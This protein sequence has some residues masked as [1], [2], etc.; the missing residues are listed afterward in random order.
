MRKLYL[1]LLG[2]V[3]FA[4]QALAQRTITG[5]VTDEKGNAL[6]NVSVVVKGTTAGTS[7]KSDGTFSLV[8]PANAKLLVVSSVDMIA[9]ELTIGSQSNFT[10]ALKADDKTLQEAVVVGYG[11][12]KKPSITGSVA[13]VKATDI[14]NKPFSSVDKIL[15][16]QVAGL[17]SV[18]ASGQPGAAQSIIIR[19][20]SSISAS[21]GPLWVVDGVPVNTG[22][23][24]RLQ[25]TANLLSTINPNDIESISVLKDAASQSIYG[26]RASN[27]VIIVTTKKGRA[28]K[29]RVRFDSELGMS[30]TAYQNKLYTPLNAQQFFDVTREG[31]INAGYGANA[32]A[33]DPIMAS[34]FGYGNGI[35]YSWLD[36]VTRNGSQQQYNLSLDGGNERTT[37][38]VSGGHFK[39]EG[40][41]INS[42]LSRNSGNIRITNKVSD[43]VTISTNIN[44]AVVNQRAPLNGGAFGNPVL[45]SYFLL[46]S[47]SAYNPDGSYNFTALGGLHNTVALTKIDKRFLRQAS[48]RGSIAA[49][50]AIRKNLKFRTSY[51]ADFNMLEEDQ[52][53]N[54]V[55]GDGVA[56]NGRSFAYYTRYYNWVW[57]NTLNWNFKLSKNGDLTNDMQVGYEA[58]KS[59]GYFASIQAQIMP[60]NFNMTMP[61][62][63]ALPI[64]ANATISEYSFLS[65]FASTN[66]NYQNRFI[67]SGSF[68]RDGS[69]RFSVNNK[70]GNFWSI[71][72]S[73]NMEKEEIIKNIKWINQLKLRAS[74]GV[75]GNAGIG[76][77]DWFQ[78]YSYGATYNQQ[79]GS[80]FSNVGDSS[81]TWEK[82]KPTNIGFDISLFKNR[83]SV[84]FDYYTRTTESLLL[85]VPLSRTSGLTSATKNLGTMENKG[86]ELTISGTP[87]VLKNFRWNIDFNFANNKNKVTALPGG[88]DIADGSFIIRQGVAYRTFFLR[89]YAGVNPVNGDPLWYTDATHANKTNAYPGGNA[90]NLVGN[91]LP[92]YFGSL[93]NNFTIGAFTVQCQLYY[94]FGNYV[95]DTWGSYYAGAGFGGSYNKVVRVLN[96]WQKPGDVTD[97]PK[98]IYGGNKSFQSSSTMWLNKGDFI[99]VRNLEVSYDVPAAIN[100]KFK[101]SRSSFYVRGTNLFT[102]VKDKNLPFD[103]EQGTGSATNMNVFIPRTIT[104]G[105]SVTF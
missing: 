19:G 64:T 47:R 74:T 101:I 17:Q 105:L 52:Y 11:T 25:T 67:L 97:I 81:L 63:G 60:V 28:G 13:A 80:Y 70:N 71:G 84:S 14:E 85:N 31:L 27:G 56:S 3:F 10:V 41:T 91:A 86:V 5:K 99:R 92:K 37:F 39:Q 89:E 21:T 95:Y 4:T 59:S 96:R 35:D 98:Y 24:S 102:Y 69:S 103:P 16:G 90:R 77:Y 58:Q 18:A 22:D 55:H 78:L 15:Q 2:V 75:N 32:A 38:F 36:A 33:V 46:P 7:T 94:N 34:N 66:L 83:F 20:I 88:N 104:M 65:K 93:T 1:L 73:W 51:G 100:Q 8:L 45:S 9:Q 61:A 26:S 40:T 54:P 72:T 48:I 42:Q 82:N 6:P 68:R 49:D 50:Y 23:A 57:T 44:G 76:N 43:K 62:V 12:Q 29:T 87:L 30:N 79:P 53:N